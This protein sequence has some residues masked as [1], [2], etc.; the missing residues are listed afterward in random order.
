MKKILLLISFLFPLISFATTYY[1][2]NAGSDAA[3]GTSLATSWATTTKVNSMMGVF[4]SGDFIRFRDGDSFTGFLIVTKAGIHIA[5]Y[6]SGAKPIITGFT[7]ITAWT[8]LGTNIWE[9]TSAISTLSHCNIVTVGGVNTAMG[10]TPNA[11]SQYTINSSNG[12]SSATINVLTGT[13]NYAGAELIASAANASWIHTRNLITSQSGSTLNTVPN[14]SNPANFTLYNYGSS[15]FIQNSASTL[16]VQNE[17]YYNPSNNK[18][19]I[20]STSSPTNVK[21][22]TIDSLIKITVANVTVDSIDFEG[23]NTDAIQLSA[24]ST[25]TIRNCDVNYCGVMGLR[26]GNSCPSLTVTNCNFR[27]VENSGVTNAFAGGS[28][29]RIVTGCTF[30]KMNMVEGSMGSID[31][32]NMAICLFDG[33]GTG[34]LIQ[35]NSID[36]CGYIGIFAI[37]Q[38]WT[39]YRNLINHYCFYN[40]DGG[41]I[42]SGNHGTNR[43]IRGNIVLNGMT[44]LAQGIYID[45]NGSNVTIDSN[46]VYKADLGIYLHNAHEIKV[47]N[48]TVYA[49]TGASLSMGHDANDPVRNVDIQRNIFVINANISQGNI[50]YGTS[51]T[52]QTN[53]GTSDFNWIAKPVGTDDNAWFTA[54]QG[55]T[56]N[57]YNLAQW[58]TA[59]PPNDAHS[60]KSPATVVLADIRFEYNATNSAVGIS[61]GGNNYI[62][63]PGVAYSG[64]LTLQPWTSAVLLRTGAGNS[65][66][67]VNAGID[68]TITLPTNSATMAG[69]ATDPDG[70][71]SSHTWTQVSGPNTAT[72]TTPGSYT[73]TMTGL[74]QG[75]YLFQL[76]ATDNSG[77]TSTD[78]MQVVVNP[79]IN[80]PPVANAGTDQNITLPTNS[81]TQVGSG[82]DPDGTISAYLWTKVSGPGSS[83]IVSPTQA[84]TVIN[85][86]AAG[87]YIFNLR[88]TDNNGAT[89][90]DQM[91]VI[92]NAANVPPTANAGT[93]QTITLPTN[94]VTLTGT[95]SDPDGTI[96]SYL[97]TKISGPATFTIVSPGQ[98]TTNVTN[99]VAGTY[100]FQLTV[101]DNQGAMASST[102]QVLVNAAPPPNQPPVVNAGTDKNITLPTNNITQIGTATDP[103]GTIASYSWSKISGPATFTIV[104][105]TTSSTQIT[106]LV[107]GTYV[108][109]LTATDNQGATGTDQMTVIVN[110]APN[111][112]PV[113]NAGPD[114]IITQ[115][116]SSSSFNGSATDPEDGPITNHTWLFIAGPATPTITTPASYTSTVTGMTITGT[117]SFRL[118]ATDAAA[119]TRFDTMQILV[120]PAPNQLPIA[121]AGTDKNIVLPTNSVTQVGSGSDPDGTIVSYL[122]T[123]LSGPTAFTIVSASQA[124]TVINNLVQGTYVFNLRVTDNSGANANDQVTIV[125]S[126]AVNQFPTA[127]AGANQ[128][129]TLPTSSVTLVGSG[130]DPDG[131]ITAYAW[132]KISGPATFNIVSPASATTVVNNLV[133]GTYVFQLQVTD[134][135]GA[136]ATNTTQV[137][138]NAAPPPNQPPI[139][140]AGTDKNITLPTNSISQVG[141]GTD[142]DGT[143]TSYQWTKISGPATFT[144]VNPFSSTTT[145]NNLVVGTYIFQL[146]VTDNQ[147]ANGTDQMTVIVNPAP[148]V[149][150]VANAGADQ[151]I[152]LPTTSSAF[153]GSATDQDGTI[154]S[155]T[156]TF[157]AG[158]ATPSITTP[159]S[160]TS[161]VTGMTVD[162]SYTFRLSVTDN[163]AATAVDD[164]IILVNAAP[165]VPPVVNAGADQTDTAG[166]VVTLTATA[167]D[168]DGTIVSRLWTQVSG[169]TTVTFNSATQL[170]TTASNLV[171]GT[172]VFRFRATDNSGAATTDDITVTMVKQGPPLFNGP[173]ANAGPD[174]HVIICVMCS[175]TS[176][177]AVGSGIPNPSPIVAYQWTKLAGPAQGNA[178]SPNTAVTSIIGL[179]RGTYVF[180]LKVTD[181]AGLTA[182]D[183]MTVDVRKNYIVWR[184]GRIIIIPL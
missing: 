153:A 145:I 136:T 4:V 112:P 106:N 128:T 177:T 140:N 17:W 16:D 13:P 49:C 41:G 14:Y 64:T 32:N 181:A 95:G 99:L 29:N 60:K 33:N 45:D 47:Y 74:I 93:N 65:F 135:Q 151:T 115:P 52:S 170:T 134:N 82:S 141:S 168:G 98:A 43:I 132:T 117:Y 8:N 11:G 40:T 123:K 156:W 12:F 19:R 59:A 87:T 88:V 183:T 66:P 20:F 137:I 10:R 69:S 105:P 84:T 25:I 146:T 133:A 139:A 24:A 92:V 160:Y 73:T 90:S 125:V 39:V 77:A 122:W 152:Q 166:Q 114:Q 147:L 21:A 121:N 86:L 76:S 56:F 162:G 118:S 34:D 23:A 75:T 55:T 174:L 85:N 89:A 6:G 58:Q 78:N 150:P 113:V 80:Q 35:N 167:T 38:S 94:S 149:P 179:V 165:N 180:Q 131:T 81:I 101:T 155:H 62:D 148:N 161:A 104:T 142:A 37:G 108:F 97:W 129:V 171:I 3:N 144:I 175:S 172:Y 30:V 31:G 157:I 119:A 173:T 116:V 53:F 61:L 63:I 83:T 158:P 143:V 26:M 50:S 111:Q 178:N 22:T 68:Q 110:P 107:A 176:V 102:V 48:N 91:T 1:V 182:T 9:S 67:V 124:T 71:I 126:P 169:P 159:S 2:S 72:I 46:T 18:L 15:G 164:M 109:Q 70:T 127:N 130:S 100:V 42:Y 28:N 96:A 57:H 120:N 7:P 44:T 36:S 103:D 27:D 154:T 5:T 184:S 54:L 163:S 51:E 138:V 79:A